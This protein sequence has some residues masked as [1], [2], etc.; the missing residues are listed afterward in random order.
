[1]SAWEKDGESDEWY[2]PKYVFDALDCEFDMDVAAP[3]DRT[4]VTVPAKTFITE[5]SLN[6]KWNGFVWMN[7]PFG[8]RN[9]KTVWLEKIKEH[10]SGIG[11]TPDRTSAPWWQKAARQVRGVL[12]VDGK[13]KF[14]RPDGT[15]G[16][17]PSTG[18]ALLAYGPRAVEVLKRAD[19]RGLGVF[20]R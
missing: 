15:T 5:G 6:M 16:K 20:K 9:S 3:V 19:K 12:F 18:T 10:G 11:L 7:P 13:I 17:S 2:T 4:Y 1:M 14:L 8:G